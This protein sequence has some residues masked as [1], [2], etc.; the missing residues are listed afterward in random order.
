MNSSIFDSHFHIIPNGYPLIENNGY[1]PDFYSAK[2][3]KRDLN[4]LTLLGGVVVSGSFQGFDQSYLLHTLKTLGKKFFG[5]ANIPLDS[6][7]KEIQQ[8]HEGGVRAVRFNFK[9]GKSIDSAD[10]LRLAKKVYDQAGWH[11][12]FYIENKNIAQY[13]S[14]FSDLPKFSIDHLG[15]SQEGLSCLLKLVESGAHVKAT[16]FGRIELDPLEAMKKI[17]AINPN[18]LMFG[19]DLP[20]T[21]ARRPFSINDIRLIE[22]NFDKNDIENILFKNALDFYTVVS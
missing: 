14:L 17:H 12:E 20:S 10:I 21:R 4:T 1:L 8:L 16:G 22:D 18:A 19:S 7:D 11:S 15:L 6:S 2:N 5:V 9:R 3:Y 13:Q